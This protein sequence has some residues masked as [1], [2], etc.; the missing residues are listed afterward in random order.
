[1]KTKI[2]SNDDEVTDVYDKKIPNVDFNHTCLAVIS[3]NSTLKGDGNYYPQ[4]FLKERRYTEKNVVRHIYNNLS[5]F[6]YSSDE[7]DEE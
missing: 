7:S 2:K 1:M 5:D 4:L 6:S 3:F